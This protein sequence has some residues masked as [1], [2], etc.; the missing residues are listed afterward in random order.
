MRTLFYILIALFFSSCIFKN[1]PND[2]KIE[3]KSEKEIVVL[4]SIKIDTVNILVYFNDI[5]KWLKYYDQYSIELKNFEFLVQEKLPDINQ[6][7]DSINLMTD[8]YYPFYK[9]SNDR[10]KILDLI[11][12]NLLLEKNEQNELES[13][14]HNVDSEVSILDLQNK[15]WKRILFVGPFYIIEDGFW[16]NNDQFIIVGQYYESEVRKYKPIIWFV[17]LEKN[18]IQTLEYKNY[19]E[20]MKCNYLEKVIYKSIKL[21]KG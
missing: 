17:D 18:I 1:E 6:T 20:K 12:Y 10:N 13:Y 8:I 16:I 4:N 2:N 3:T 15:L 9:F 7:V 21:A 5:K 11:S 14:G 19:I